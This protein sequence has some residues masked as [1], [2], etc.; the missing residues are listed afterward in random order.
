MPQL[1][2]S[3]E[4]RKCTRFHDMRHPYAKAKIKEPN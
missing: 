1:H 4:I 2:L 3:N